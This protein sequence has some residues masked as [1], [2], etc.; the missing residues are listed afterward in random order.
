M[1]VE[2]EEGRRQRVGFYRGVDVV[3][4]TFER[5]GDLPLN[6][7]RRGVPEGSGWCGSGD[8]LIAA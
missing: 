1:I 8:R 6:S 7:D 2:V 3:S 4:G 5:G